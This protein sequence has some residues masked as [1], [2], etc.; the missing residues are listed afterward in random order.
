[1]IAHL[2]QKNIDIL[3]GPVK[4]TG[5]MGPMMSVYINDLD[6]NLIEISRYQSAEA[7][8]KTDV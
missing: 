3:E 2:K 8:A 5:A 1:V 6:N 4:K 7:P